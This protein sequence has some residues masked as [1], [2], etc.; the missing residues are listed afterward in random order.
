M[1]KSHTEKEFENHIG[2]I[3]SHILRIKNSGIIISN[4]LVTLLAELRRLTLSY[5]LLGNVCTADTEFEGLV[6]NGIAVLV[7]N[8]NLQVG[9]FEPMVAY[10]VRN[11]FDETGDPL[12]KEVLHLMG[13]MKFSPQSTGVLMEHYIIRGIYQFFSKRME[14]NEYFEIMKEDLPDWFCDL[15]FPENF[16]PIDQEKKD[17]QLLHFLKDG[18]KELF[19]PEDLARHDIVAYL[20]RKFDLQKPNQLL[21][22]LDRHLVYMQI[23]F[24]K[25]QMTPKKLGEAFKTTHPEVAYGNKRMRLKEEIQ[26]VSKPILQRGY[27]RLLFVFPSPEKEIKAGLPFTVERDG[28]EVVNIYLSQRR[29]PGLFKQEVWDV[30]EKLKAPKLS[31]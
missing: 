28:S 3:R 24:L 9:I 27:V 7:R 29:S 18:T 15:C 22:D 5:F 16:P 2:S 30:L 21:Q 6:E 12:E 8:E 19:F 23:K 26:K 11:Y 17:H 31:N 25:D 10:A 13:E 1:W 4:G 14:E 20:Y